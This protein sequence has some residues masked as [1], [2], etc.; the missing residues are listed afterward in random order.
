MLLLAH[1]MRLRL[2]AHVST[3]F[4][5]HFIATPA[6]CAATGISLALGWL[7]RPAFMQKLAGGRPP[8]AR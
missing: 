7:T 6:H 4:P 5:A 8:H 2:A 1:I 3:F